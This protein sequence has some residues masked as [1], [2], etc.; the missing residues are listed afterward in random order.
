MDLIEEGNLPASQLNGSMD[1][2]WML[3]DMDFADSKDIRPQF[4]KAQLQDG[5]LDLRNVELMG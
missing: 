4:F 1:L 2:G 3:Y 5:V